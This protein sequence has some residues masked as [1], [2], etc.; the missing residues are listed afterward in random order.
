M[1]NNLDPIIKKTQEDLLKRK[2]ETPL[3]KLVI[4]SNTRDFYNAVKN[5]KRGSVAIIA[6]VKFASPNVSDLSSKTSLDERVRQY[7]IGA[8]AISI[9]T[10]KHFFKGDPKFVSQ[11]KEISLLPVLQKDFIIDPYQLYEVAQNNADAV[12]LIAKILSEKELKSFV[13]IAQRLNLEPVVE[14]NNELDLKKATKTNTRIIAVNARDLTSFIVDVD[15]A[16]ILIKKIPNRFLKLGFSGVSSRTQ[17]KKYKQAGANGVLI[18]TT[19]M[20][21]Q[22]I[23][24]YL[25]RVR[26]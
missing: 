14:V 21:T 1:Q 24:D 11:I 5:P 9:V 19:L 2:K 6:E 25:E 3:K 23:T 17:I 16:C 22:K 15:R 7:D 4:S 12:L 20:K 26:V 8:D 10:E 13:E 18:G